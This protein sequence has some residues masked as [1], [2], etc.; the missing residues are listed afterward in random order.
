MKKTIHLILTNK[1]ESKNIDY[2][3]DLQK[4]IVS[5]I[6]QSLENNPDIYV[7]IYISPKHI[8]ES[9]LENVDKNNDYI[10]WHPVVAHNNLTLLKTYRNSI[11][12]LQKKTVL[13]QKVSE[14]NP[15]NENMAINHNFK[16]MYIDENNDDITN[17]DYRIL[18]YK[19]DYLINME[20]VIMKLTENGISIK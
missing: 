8:I 18:G 13:L 19:G 16:L 10:I 9:T 11:V 15:I 6:K 3:L 2:H 4:K 1:I 20:K 7:K 17:Q 12:I 5:F 14:N